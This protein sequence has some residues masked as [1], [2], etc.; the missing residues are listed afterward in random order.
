ML[1]LPDSWSWLTTL[2]L[3][4]TVMVTVATGLDYLVSAIRLRR[5]SQ[6]TA[7][8]LA[9]RAEAARQARPPAP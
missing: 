1:P 8:K 5:G 3:G 9:A 2:L 7:A 4:A 6:R